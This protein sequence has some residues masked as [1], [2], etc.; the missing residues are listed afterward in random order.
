MGETACPTHFAKRLIQQGGAGGFAC[1]SNGHNQWSAS[2]M[3][4]F[5]K[6]AKHPSLWTG[7]FESGWNECCCAAGC[8]VQEVLRSDLD[9]D[10]SGRVRGLQVG[11]KSSERCFDALSRQFR[12]CAPA[13]QQSL[14]GWPVILPAARQVGQC[15]PSILIPRVKSQRRLEMVEGLRGV[16]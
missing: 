5:P 1:R 3:N 16:A 10:F 12:V 11:T 7:H 2:K 14:S 6:T 9:V 8:G 4:K 15:T 13:P